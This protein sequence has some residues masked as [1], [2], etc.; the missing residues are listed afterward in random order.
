[1]AEATTTVRMDQQ[2]R[3]VIPKPVRE[4]L[5]IDWDD[6]DGDRIPVEV[7]VRT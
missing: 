5:G 4:K 1:M 6:V 3:V 7:E 2:G